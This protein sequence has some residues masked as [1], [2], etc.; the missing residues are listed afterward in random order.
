MEN[1]LT[2]FGNSANP[3]QKHSGLGIASFVISILA[4]AAIICLVAA[5]GMM[6]A[7]TPGGIDEKAPATILM[8]LG[9]V[10]FVLLDFVALGLGIAAFFQTERNK[11]FAILGTIFSGV[12][13][14]GTI[15]LIAFGT[16]IR[17][18]R[19]GPPQAVPSHSERQLL[20]QR[21]RLPSAGGSAE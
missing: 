1:S 7:T 10:A 20:G 13:V 15:A 5:A 12:M 21:P 11:L 16:S 6:E 4:G 3:N 17:Q 19:A 2:D 8:G 14:A 9:I 18:H